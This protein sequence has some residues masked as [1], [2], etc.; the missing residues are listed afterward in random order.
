MI[1]PTSLN[2]SVSRKHRLRVPRTLL[3]LLRTAR[4]GT[5]RLAAGATAIA[6][7]PAIILSTLHGSGSLKS[8]LFD[9]A[10][11]SRLLI[12]IPLLILAEPVLNAR[13][14]A[15]ARH[16]VASDL[17]K[18]EDLSRFEE[19]FTAFRRRVNSRIARV[20]IVMLIYTFV[21]YAFS[22]LRL[23]VL[24]EW[25]YAAGTGGELSAAGS[26][27]I[28]VSLPLVLYLLLV[29]V[30]R[31]VLWSW[32]LRSV[33][34]LDLRLIPS[35][36]DLMGGLGFLQ[37]CLRG[38]LPLGFAIATVVAGGVANRVIHQHHSLMGFKYAPLIVVAMVLVLCVGPLCTFCGLLQRTRRRGIF[39]YGCLGSD[40]GHQ[41]EAKWLEPNRAVDSA[42]LEKPDFSAT[43]DLYSVVAYVH[44]MRFF[45]VGLQSL[46]E[47][48]A[49]T[50][51]PAVPIALIAVPFDVLLEGAM[52]LVL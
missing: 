50:L 2:Y 42:V 46:S 47:V 22:S 12:V 41:F 28:L 4:P 44:Q 7:F 36:P 1:A 31:Q 5:I 40:L 20:V 33:S 27:Y 13:L 16:F 24:Q 43:I 45:P 38:C 14:E 21:A 18:K 39:E 19:M 29:W 25:C 11:Q 23:G 15:V 3:E 34:H 51:I 10:A 52:K 9:F 49:A 6:W 26:W 48:A 37:T 17:V 30:W 32:F 35:H 8:F